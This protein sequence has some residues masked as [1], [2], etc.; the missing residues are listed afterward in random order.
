MR[1]KEGESNEREERRRWRSV[2]FLVYKEGL[3][4]IWPKRSGD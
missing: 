4:K 2:F 1:A 3:S